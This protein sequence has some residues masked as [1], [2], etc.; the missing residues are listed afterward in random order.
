MNCVLQDRV[1]I[2]VYAGA[3]GKV[4]DSTPGDEN[5]KFWKR[6]KIFL[7]EVQRPVAKG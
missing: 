6:W 4:L 2:V 3:A 5:K 1:S 7:L